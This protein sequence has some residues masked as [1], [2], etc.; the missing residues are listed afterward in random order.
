MLRTLTVILSFALLP[1]APA[2]A[3]A[4]EEK[5]AEIIRI[6]LEVDFP[7]V[8]QEVVPAH[9]RSGPGAQ[10]S[11]LGRE[12][13]L[14]PAWK[15][16]EAHW[17]RA[18]K[19]LKEDY[20]G[21]YERA[22]AANR[23]RR[24]E[25]AATLGELTDAQ[26]DVVLEFYGSPVFR[27]WVQATDEA[28]VAM[29]RLF[30]ALLEPDKSTQGSL[31][32][33]QIV[34][35]IGYGGLT[36][37][38]QERVGEFLQSSTYKRM[39]RGALGALLASIEDPYSARVK[40]PLRPA[41]S[42]AIGRLVAQFREAH[43]VPLPLP[44][45][46]SSDLRTPQEHALRKTADAAARGD[47]HALARIREAAEAGDAAAQAELGRLYLLGRGAVAMDPKAAF[48]WT[49]KAAAQGMARAQYNLG[50]Q[51]DGGIGVEHDVTLAVENYRRAAEQGFPRAQ[52]ALGL[53]YRSGT[54]V[55]QD[56]QRSLQLI[57]AAADRYLPGAELAMAQIYDA[58]AGI[59]R[60]PREADRWLDRARIQGYAPA[61]QYLNERKAKTAELVALLKASPP[62]ARASAG[63]VDRPELN[64]RL[65]EAAKRESL[66]SVRELLEAGADVNVGE[67]EGNKGQTSLHQAARAGSVELASL[68]VS[69]GA[70]VNARAYGDYTPLH[71][72]AGLGQRAVA[73]YLIGK[74]ADINALAP[75]QGAPLHAATLQ[76]QARMVELLLD[77]G[78]DPNIQ[79]PRDAATPLHMFSD[80]GRY[81]EPGHTQIIDTLTR[82]GA[83]INA[84]KKNGSTPLDRAHRD[85]IS[86]LILH[87]A[88]LSRRDD[89]YGLLRRAAESGR[90]EPLAFLEQR[91]LSLRTK[92]P[93]GETLLHV[94]AGEYETQALRYL[95]SKG[96]D[97][98]AADDT[99]RT[100]LYFAVGACRKPNV[101]LL[102]EK[103]ARAGAAPA[104]T[105]T[106]LHAI[107]GEGFAFYRDACEEAVLALLAADPDARI[108]G[109]DGT[110][111]LH[112]AADQE[113]LLKKLLELGADAQARDD[114]GQT[115]LHRFIAYG[116]RPEAV[117][118]LVRAGADPNAQDA[119]GSTP[120]HEFSE[121]GIGAERL[122][123][124][125]A[126]VRNGARSNVRN[127]KGET[128][129]D[130]FEK[131][132]W[133][134]HPDRWSDVSFI[135]LL[136]G[137]MPPSP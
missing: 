87:G 19:L 4:R 90:S 51:Y 24:A 12:A 130:A 36:A 77:K 100:A 13:E 94:A 101:E 129:L 108:R 127:A 71:V 21:M 122:A 99:G 7:R 69:R 15:A 34:R 42:E 59:N 89:S 22:S 124:A 8:R 60:D 75:Y 78:A 126:L 20:L 76:G 14:G 6:L 86:A 37:G 50:V 55:P 110:A 136:K 98:N 103:G 117:D 10:L 116:K 41:T 125:K 49:R 107:L 70:N 95:I 106:A 26:L 18:E 137:E 17:D 131:T 3:Q 128:P 46:H 62:S 97:L 132:P 109:K 64:R 30:E 118:T 93:K 73:E 105:V 47:T 56:F 52:L 79:R 96:L 66:D 102:L 57:Q 61:S 65:I 16:G 63:A 2:Q 84:T 82:R 25:C 31:E 40:G 135:K 5:I 133:G 104:G 1:S 123:I 81:M 35:A 54:G 74:G 43:G 45:A 33:E 53:K 68:L 23:E 111:P 27:K 39:K 48:E 38:E 120:L 114:K 72:A 134:K 28:V 91:G 9:A 67:G 80:I 11:S 29:S 112:V 119:L 44:A 113:H 121:W 92:G 58:G 32:Q 88:L 85:A 115:P 83:D